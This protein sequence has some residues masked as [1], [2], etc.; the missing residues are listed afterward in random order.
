MYELH[1]NEAMIDDLKTINDMRE[2]LKLLGG[3]SAVA[4]LVD[5]DPSNISKYTARGAFPA[6]WAKVIKEAASRKGAI[7]CD[8][9]FRFHS[10]KNTT[11]SEV[12]NDSA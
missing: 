5:K 6:T 11:Q 7:I 3:R 2:A 4:V 12:S 9:L 1:F 10:A 8:S